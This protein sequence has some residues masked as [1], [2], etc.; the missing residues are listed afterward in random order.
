M[1]VEKEIGR[2]LS[3]LKHVVCCITMMQNCKRS[4]EWT[5][6]QTH[7]QTLP[8]FERYGRGTVCVKGT[9]CK[10]LI[11]F[12]IQDECKPRSSVQVWLLINMLRE[13]LESAE[14]G[15]QHYQTRVS[16]CRDAPHKGT[17][18]DRCSQLKPSLKSR[19]VKGDELD[20]VGIGVAC[21]SCNAEKRNT[22]GLMRN[23]ATL[24]RRHAV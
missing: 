10:Y 2:N 22:I 4:L 19:I 12:S 11:T 8:A 7:F 18:L 15:Y 21:V 17:P 23:E 14:G 13:L 3:G 5:R 1:Q 20:S 16:L 6:Q 24:V 9:R